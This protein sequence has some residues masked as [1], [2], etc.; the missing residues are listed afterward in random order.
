MNFA[1]HLNVTLLA[2][3]DWD[4]NAKKFL[5]I[6]QVSYKMAMS[7]DWVWLKHWQVLRNK[8]QRFILGK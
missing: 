6:G 3:E 2:Q 8:T 7:F 4:L 1:E 5:L